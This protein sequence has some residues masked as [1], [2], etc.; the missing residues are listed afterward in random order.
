M[1]FSI[2][3]CFA[4]TAVL[5]LAGCGGSMTDSTYNP[6]IPNLS[7][8]AAWEANFTLPQQDANG[9]SI[10]TPSADSRLIYVSTSGDD[11]TA[12]TYTSV[13]AEVG[14]DLYNP[15]AVLPYATLDAALAQARAGYPD[16]ILLRR[17]DTWTR[18]AA[19]AMKAGRSATERM[20]LAC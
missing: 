15:G 3:L 14:A 11:G 19:I 8:P 13:S 18:T 5:Q 10:L 17:G 12:Q 4:A 6:A 20:V 7:P 1:R 16:Y 9:W 2:W